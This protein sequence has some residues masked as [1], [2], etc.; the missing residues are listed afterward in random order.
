MIVWESTKSLG[1]NPETEINPKDQRNCNFLSKFVWPLEFE[2]QIETLKFDF[3]GFCQKNGLRSHDNITLS[4][5]LD[6]LKTF[7]QTCHL[8]YGK[9][10][11]KENFNGVP[12]WNSFTPGIQII[13]DKLSNNGC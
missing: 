2:I 12:R 1:L 9:N 13:P 8:E 11:N 7:M 4:W 5:I 6:C 3:R 10:E